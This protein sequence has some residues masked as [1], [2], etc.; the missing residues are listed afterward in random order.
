VCS[1]M[2][3][4]VAAGGTGRPLSARAPSCDQ[5]LLVPG[6]RRGSAPSQPRNSRVSSAALTATDSREL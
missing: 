1:F 6:G 5:R 3:L 2:R 4:R